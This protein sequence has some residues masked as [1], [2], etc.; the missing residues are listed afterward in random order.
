LRDFI[1]D[2]LAGYVSNGRFTP[3]TSLAH[4]LSPKQLAFAS[5][6]IPAHNGEWS[7]YG[8]GL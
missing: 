2:S 8:A 7:T 6:I 3:P 5:S 1:V 4:S